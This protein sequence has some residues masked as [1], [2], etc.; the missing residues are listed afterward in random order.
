MSS[1]YVE[2]IIGDMQYGNNKWM[3]TPNG[4]DIV[5]DLGLGDY[6]GKNERFSLLLALK[7]I[8][9]NKPLV[10]SKIYILS[11]ETKPMES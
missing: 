7:H 3:C 2:M 9:I 6:S 1:D 5:F 10:T 4:K 11:F 8:P